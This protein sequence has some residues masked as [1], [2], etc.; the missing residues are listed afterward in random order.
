[1]PLHAELHRHLGGAV[2][3]RIFWRFLHRQ[4][5]PLAARYPEY[6]AFEAFITHP[7]ASL[8]E[9]LELHTLVEGVQ[10]LDNLPY[11]VSKLVRGA[12]VFE[13]ILYLELR[14]TPYY[15]TDTNLSEADRIAQ[16]REVVQVIA[17][18][19]YQQDYPLRMRQIL[20]MHSRLPV[21][22]NRATIELAAKEPDKV[23][24]VDLAG[25]D[26]LYGPR[27][28]DFVD[29]FAYARSFGLKTTCHLFETDNGF[30][31]ELLPYLDRIG[32][33][34]Q[35]PLQR[36]EL[37]PV[38]AARG[39]CLEVCPTSYLKTG[40]LSDLSALRTV[41]ERCEAAG[42]DIAL[43]TDNPGLHNVRLPFEF[44]N[45]LTQ[46]VIDFKQ[47][48]RCQQAAFRHAFAWPHP[49]P[50]DSLLYSLAAPDL[51]PAAKSE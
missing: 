1:M 29:L 7:R 34:I 42:V 41:F 22:V 12:Y 28:L 9:F 13:G 11:F 43:C 6:E 4:G 50:P 49:E 23:C 19:G 35:I 26:T 38:I 47:L 8:T 45:L 15:R 3:P 10:R 21:S 46:D 14:Y 2:V 30:Y 31:P 27:L 16:M 17:K 24:G 37:L 36:P 5:H 48:R 39:Q 32:H 44:E 25:P 40:T 33:G 18:A 20:C 51:R